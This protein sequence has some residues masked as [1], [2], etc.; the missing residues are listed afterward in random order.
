MPGSPEIVATI[1]KKIDEA[2]VFV[3]DVTPVVVSANGKHMANPNVLIELGYAKKALGPDRIILVWNT[4]ITDCKVEDLPFDLRHRR[5][6]LS[7]SLPVDSSSQDLKIARSKLSSNLQ[8]AIAACLA[9]IEPANAQPGEASWELTAVEDPSIW[10]TGTSPLVV[11][12]R[13]DEPISMGIDEGPRAYARLL[14]TNWKPAENYRALIDDSFHPIPLGRFSGLDWGRTTGGYLA[15]RSSE[16]IQE[17]GRTPTATRFFSKTGEIWGVANSFFTETHHGVC[18]SDHYAVIQWLS[19]L[20]RSVAVCSAVGGSGPF[21][22]KLGVSTIANTIWPKSSWSSGGPNVAVEDFLELTF[23]IQTADNQE[24]V[25][26][27]RQIYNIV[28]DAYGLD[29]LNEE[30]FRQEFE[31]RH[32]G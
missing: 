12:R 2:A 10:L 14:P 21:H 23:Q 3:A 27:V 4:A 11:N 29:M 32:L 20:R 19:W 31:S 30:G 5:G 25:P 1:F 24:I 28:R 26:I 6:P 8:S 16:P 7:F 17:R 9:E 18:F 13:H 22:V 15:Y